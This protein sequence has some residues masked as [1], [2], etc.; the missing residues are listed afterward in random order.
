MPMLAA[1]VCLS[2][3]FKDVFVLVARYPLAVVADR[4]GRHQP[5]VR[6][7]FIRIVPSDFVNFSALL[8]R[9]SRI[10]RITSASQETATGSGGIS[11]RRA[12]TSQDRG[13]SIRSLARDLRR[14][15]DLVSEVA[16]HPPRA[17]RHPASV[18]IMSRMSSAPCF[19]PVTHSASSGFSLS[20]AICSSIST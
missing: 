2:K 20:E 9:F 11:Q 12:A 5:L 3:F 19:A 15:R 10:R 17:D 13:K 16:F 1:T 7:T 14:G 18:V 6:S 8:M 4:Y